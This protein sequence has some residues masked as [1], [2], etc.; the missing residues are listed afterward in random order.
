MTETYTRNEQ[1]SGPSFIHARINTQPMIDSIREYLSGTQK[2]Y[3][4]NEDGLLLEYTSQVSTAKANGIGIN[5][6]CSIIQMRVNSHTV[7]GNFMRDDY[8]NYKYYARISIATELV[9]K[10]HEWD[11]NPSDIDGMIDTIMALIIPF[12]SRLINNKERESYNQVETREVL[13]SIP[14]QQGVLGFGRK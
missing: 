13:Q 8:E 10:C 2:T 11:I 5:S 1:T 7:Q 12:M 9:L 14:Q 4:K 6:I 3:K